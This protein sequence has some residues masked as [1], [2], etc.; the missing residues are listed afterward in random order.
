[1]PRSG[2]LHIPGGYYHVMGREIGATTI[3]DITELAMFFRIGLNPFYAM[4]A[5]I[6]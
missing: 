1:M 4:Q 6:Y 2:R 3:A 5:P